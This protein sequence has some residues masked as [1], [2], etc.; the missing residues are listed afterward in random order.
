[1]LELSHP[2]LQCH[3]FSFQYVASLLFPLDM[4]LLNANLVLVAVNLLMESRN[5]ALKLYTAE[6][7]LDIFLQVS[8]QSALFLEEVVDRGHQKVDIHV[9]T[10]NYMLL[11]LSL[12]LPRIPSCKLQ[13]PVGNF[14]VLITK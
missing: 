6:L 2:F 5:N 8:R 7:R 1:M 12:I 3:V 14:A 9:T 13:K 4:L 11:G 10:S